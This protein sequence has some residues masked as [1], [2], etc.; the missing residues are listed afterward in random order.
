M[1]QPNRFGREKLDK[2][3][4]VSLRQVVRFG[5]W[6]FHENGVD[7]QAQ[8]TAAALVITKKALAAGLAC[9]WAHLDS[10]QEPTDYE[11]AALTVELWALSG[12][13]II[14]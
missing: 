9:W 2:A 8:N 14:I 13:T 4:F 1:S 5:G 7:G 6:A 10:N 12:S 11:S 3:C